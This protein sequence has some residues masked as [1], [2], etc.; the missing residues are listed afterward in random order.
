[1]DTTLCPSHRAQD[2][3]R[4]QYVYGL[5][6]ALGFA[7]TASQRRQCQKRKRVLSIKFMHETVMD[8]RPRSDILP[9]ILQ[10]HNDWNSFAKWKK[11]NKQT[12]AK[13]IAPTR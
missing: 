5:Y 13:I 7:G 6:K 9:H 8:S 2:H 4:L 12:L 1:M 3:T 11:K 10:R